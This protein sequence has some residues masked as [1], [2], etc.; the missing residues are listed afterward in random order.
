MQL[1]IFFCIRWLTV[2]LLQCQI[3]SNF[4]LQNKFCFLFLVPHFGGKKLSRHLE[5]RMLRLGV[6]I[7]GFPFPLSLGE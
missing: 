2:I 3:L 5:E 7:T 1:Y 6:K 4:A